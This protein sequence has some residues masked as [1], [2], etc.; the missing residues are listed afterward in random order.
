MKLLL[1]VEEACSFLQMNERTLKSGLISGTLDIGSA[2]ITKVIN[3]KPRYKYHIPIKRAEKY[4]GI[5][6]E[7]FLKMR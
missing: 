6:Y 2:I 5:S 3:N 4:M 7:D 1:N